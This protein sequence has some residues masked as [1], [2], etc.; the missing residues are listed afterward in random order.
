MKKYNFLDLLFSKESSAEEYYRCVEADKELKE[1]HEA[2]NNYKKMYVSKMAEVNKLTKRNNKIKRWHKKL[3]HHAM[4]LEEQ[5]KEMLEMLESTYAVVK[6][7]KG[8]GLIIDP[9]WIEE[10]KE[11]IEKIEGEQNG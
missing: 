5:N 7:S 4:K 8:K 11:I 1:L 3:M 10:H 9:L 6:Y 2:C